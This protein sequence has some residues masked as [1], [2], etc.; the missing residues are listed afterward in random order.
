MMYLIIDHRELNPLAIIP[1]DT[2]NKI[3]AFSTRLSSVAQGGPEAVYDGASRENN[4][5]C[6]ITATATAL[7]AAGRT[8]T[9]GD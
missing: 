4:P 2:H 9:L 6:A 7:N 3:D 1:Q 5:A 8:G